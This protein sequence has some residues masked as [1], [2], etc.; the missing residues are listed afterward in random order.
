MSKVIVITGAGSGLGRSLARWF[1]ADGNRVVLLGRTL[2]KLE[3]V[4][5]ELGDGA[6]VVACD[7]SKPDEVRAAFV[8]IAARHPVIDVLIN[9]AA[10]IDFSTLAA[11]S[12][13]HILG[14]VGANLTGTLLCSRAA[15][16]M[17]AKGGHI[18]NVS[19]G[20]VDARDPHLVVYQATKGAI[21]VMSRHL[22]DEV[23]S[24]GI[25]VTLVR[26]GPM[27]DEDMEPKGNPEGARA[28]RVACLERGIDLAKRPISYF[29]SV[30][31]VFRSL[32]DMPAD[33][34]VGT[35]CFTS[36]RD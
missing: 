26:A 2:S 24:R 21:E 29:N 13:Q 3:A 5:K 8:A 10:I 30:I 18:I 20:S 32:I 17:M 27:Y 36:R 28:F 4:A 15:L 9:N 19:S 7:I 1:A 14:I 31:W 11:A 25:R 6:M 33:M 22:Q 23:E 16:A 34:H 12:D 35:V